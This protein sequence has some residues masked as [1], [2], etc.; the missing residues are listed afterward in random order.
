MNQRDRARDLVARLI[1]AYN[2]KDADAVA[3]LYADDIRLWSTLG[4][5]SR[6]REPVVGHIRQLF[7]RLPDEQMVAE[8]VVTDGET[9]VVE[10]TSHGTGRDGTA[11][12]VS[13]TEFLWMQGNR[14]AGIETYIDPDEVAAI[15]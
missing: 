9:L 3:A 11:Y 5:D 13:F 10:L 12:E 1:D 14:I 15:S 7:S 4:E 8:V 2:A 6:G